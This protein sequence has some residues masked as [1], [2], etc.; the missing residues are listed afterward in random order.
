MSIEQPPQDENKT[1]SSSYW[2][3][4]DP[5]T[6]KKILTMPKNSERI[7]N[8]PDPL[9][10]IT[11]LFVKTD[12]P[13]DVVEIFQQTNTQLIEMLTNI[14][15]N[16]AQQ[17]FDFE[18]DNAQANFFVFQGHADSC[19]AVCETIKKLILTEPSRYTIHEAVDRKQLDLSF[20]ALSATDKTL[21]ATIT[22]SF[23]NTESLETSL[24]MLE[25]KMDPLWEE[26]RNHVRDT[27][28]KRLN[29]IISIEDF[30]SPILFQPHFI[31][32]EL[33][34]GSL[35]VEKIMNFYSD[36]KEA[37]IFMEKIENTFAKSMGYKAFNIPYIREM[38]NTDTKDIKII[39]HPL[40]SLIIDNNFSKN[41]FTEGAIPNQSVI[42]NNYQQVFNQDA[43]NTRLNWNNNENSIEKLIESIIIPNTKKI[44]LRC[45]NKGIVPEFFT[46]M[47]L[48]EELYQMRLP[49]PAQSISII[50]LP[51]SNQIS[52]HKREMYYQLLA[53]LNPRNTYVV[54]SLDPQTGSLR[55]VDKDIIANK[56]A[57]KDI[58]IS[59]CG[60]Y[61]HS[62]LK[63]CTEDVEKNCAIETTIISNT[64][65]NLISEFSGK[66]AHKQN[67][68]QAYLQSDVSFFSEADLSSSEKIFM[69][70]GQNRKKI[71]KITT[72]YMKIMTQ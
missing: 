47:E 48:L 2:E 43:T 4:Y 5:I 37:E 61:Q 24:S 10:K 59:L 62:C 65:L 63:G 71:Q 20:A 33:S 8:N 69:W 72:Q 25:K 67:N 54:E 19:N 38:P 28:P 52:P 3:G 26:L 53:T 6:G 30:F 23:K 44:Q 21:Q 70:Y 36:R 12:I 9:S 57:N 27:N 18:Q 14:G 13:I 60:G 35:A 31:A 56:F 34:Q 66:S 50:V 29:D 32:E 7:I 16:Q 58:A 51:A 39:V 46:V 15:W 42:A 11:E 49:I 64:N 40:Y 1:S 45:A 41:F 55:A 17:T 22:N 68:I